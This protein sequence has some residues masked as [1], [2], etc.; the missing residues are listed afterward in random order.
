M[1]IHDDMFHNF[2]MFSFISF[3]NTILY[4]VSIISFYFLLITFLSTIQDCIVTILKIL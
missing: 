4:N 1:I 3:S 2:W